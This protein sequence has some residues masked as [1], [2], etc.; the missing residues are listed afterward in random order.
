MKTLL[1]LL[2]LFCGFICFGQKK[3]NDVHQPIWVKGVSTTEVDFGFNYN[4]RIPFSSEFPIL[5]KKF[6]ASSYTYVFYVLK[7]SK[8]G[9]KLFSIFDTAGLHSFYTDVIKSNIEVNV[10]LSYLH[11]GALVNFNFPNVEYKNKND[12]GIFYLDNTYDK[13]TT[14]LYE[15]LVCSDCADSFLRDKIETYLAIKYG[16][17]LANT[18]KYWSS[19]GVKVWDSQLNSSFNN[20]IIGLAKDSYFGLTQVATSSNEEEDVVL[21]KSED[22]VE[23]LD[24][25][26]LLLGD[27]GGAKA[28]DNQNNRF[29]R[30]WLVQNKGEHDMLV[31]F[32][33]AVTPEKDI[34]Y[35]LYTSA[36]SEFAY[37]QGDTLQLN[38]KNIAV[39][40]QTD[41]YWSIGRVQPLSIEIQQDST[42]IN[43]SYRLLTHGEAEPPFSIQAVDLVTQEQHFFITENTSFTLE[44]LPT[45]TYSFQVNDSQQQQATLAS[46]ALDF[47]QSDLIAMPTTWALNGR[48]MLVI[49]PQLKQTDLLYGYRWFL[50]DK[51]ISTAPVLRVN[52]PGSF[53]LE[54]TDQRG[55]YQRFGFTVDKQKTTSSSV[56]EQWLV[57]PNP[58]KAGEEF[59][60]HYFF[61]SDKYVDFYI[62]TLE[63]KFIKREKHGLIAGGTYTYR[64][65]GKTTYLLVSI[66]NS[67]TSIQKLIVK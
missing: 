58:V 54:M 5:N 23:L 20:H 43:R 50:G 25:S 3:F 21:K 53:T 52:Y 38:F 1:S 48:E 33:V 32:T 36:G 61:E 41:M 13:A 12:K 28:F 40:R 55:K 24:Q 62:Y 64:L 66:I 17:T 59:K 44:G 22:Q 51:I 57:S 27:N 2:V 39:N 11:H 10:D 65:A 67:K 35:Y 9:E 56:D 18:N 63:G 19:S 7:S 14:A 42:G 30:Q 29:K 49:Q 26:Y 15:V 6:T 47:G 31:D 37:D 16:I 45:S 46:I 34:E 8:E 4:T 60:V